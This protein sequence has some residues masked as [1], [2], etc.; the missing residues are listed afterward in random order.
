MSKHRNALDRAESERLAYLMEECSEA[1]QICAKVLRHGYESC[2]PLDPQGTNRE[3]LQSELADVLN[4]IQM[5][6]T[7]TDI[8]M[9]CI[10][11]SR[12]RDRSRYFHFQQQ[13]HGNE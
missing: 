5:M 11:S 6:A 4:A 8:N 2:N 13:E 10:M 12:D 9:A 3:L 1:I 7:A